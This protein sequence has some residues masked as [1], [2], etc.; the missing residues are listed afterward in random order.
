MSLPLAHER[1][2]CARREVRFLVEGCPG[3]RGAVDWVT[4]LSLD[5]IRIE[6]RLPLWPNSELDI[7]VHLPGGPLRAR[8]A[9]VAGHPSGTGMRFLDLGPEDRQ[10]LRDLLDSE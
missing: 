1:R 9:I 6:R 8:A 4:N 5:G 7:V 10:R 3:I 2:H